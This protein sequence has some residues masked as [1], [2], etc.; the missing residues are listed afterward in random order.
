M[1]KT[2][3]FAVL[4]SLAVCAAS[5]AFPLAAV[6]AD[7]PSPSPSPGDTP[8]PAEQ[9]EIDDIYANIN[10]LKQQLLDLQQ[11]LSNQ[12]QP[13]AA[14]TAPPVY[15]PKIKLT[16]PFSVEVLGNRSQNVELTVKNLGT[17]SAISVLV[18]ASAS[19]DAPFTLSFPDGSNSFASLGESSTKTIVMNV[20]TD[21]DAKP[22]AYTVTLNYS[23]KSADST[24]MTES[25][26][27]TVKVMGGAAQSGPYVIFHDFKSDTEPIVPGD[28]VTVSAILENTGAS[29]ANNVQVT[30]DGFDSS[31]HMTG[32]PATFFST[33]PGNTQTVCN[34]P[35][36]V[37]GSAKQGTYPLMFKVSYADSLGATATNSFVYY[38]NVNSAATSGDLGRVTITGIDAPSGAFGVGQ[39]FTFGVHIKNTGSGAAS[40][41]EIIASP[42]DASIVPKSVNT[43]MIDSLAAGDTETVTF[44]FAATADA[45]TQN[46]VVDFKLSYQSGAIL[47]DGSAD[48]ASIEQ[49]AG[50]NISVPA[51]ASP[52]PTPVPTPE[53]VSKPK[54][55]I[56]S[57]ATDPQIVSAGQ[58]FNLKIIFR[59]THKDKTVEN[60]KIILA[61]LDTTNT[62]GSVFTP[63]DCSNTIYIDQ[64][65]PGGT[66]E[67]DMTMYTVP[68]AAPRTYTIGVNYEY[69]D[70]D[71]NNYTDTE[72]I[73]INVKQVTK[74]E[75]SEISI[76]TD[77][78]PGQPIPLSFQIINSGKV[79]LS[80]LRVSVDSN[81]DNSNASAYMGTL[82][83]GNSTS[84]D[85]YITPIDPG[86]QQGTLTISAEDSTGEV[87]SIQQD[88]EVNVMDYS[89]GYDNGG[90]VYP[91]PDYSGGGDMGGGSMGFL[92]MFKSLSQTWAIVAEAAI[93]VV[94][95]GGIAALVIVRRRR[96]RR[97][98]Q[99]DYDE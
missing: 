86:V 18:Q 51:S 19:G 79:D 21:E 81:M 59:N 8:P 66:Y 38:L 12:A 49:Y 30:V 43:Q 83:S 80:N 77:G 65:P 3:F 7:D 67:K 85:G 36:T 60:I 88:F 72:Q 91:A 35:I 24:N 9:S 48:A 10:A 47:D 99:E 26:T 62:A 95:V 22:G 20:K 2:K 11:Q 13:P 69:Q 71:F 23:Y 93:A 31:I 54:I 41:I 17:S 84:F 98:Q 92:G 76:P 40:N 90:D 63:V 6:Y 73:G 1:K 61:A 33:M 52:S 57:Y 46:Y 96:R 74:L 45:N 56:D 27:L 44:T 53:G 58:N 55:V 39:N 28:N 16:S 32:T 64:I 15:A 70:E 25:D 78:A 97:R 50:V 37:S 4:L 5:V 75:T 89:G 42:M 68:D 87:V 94:V 34:I 14:T 29:D 82:K